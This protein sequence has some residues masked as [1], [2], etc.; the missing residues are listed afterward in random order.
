MNTDKRRALNPYLAGAIAGTVATAPMTLTMELL[1]RRLPARQQQPLPPRRLTM[2]VARRTRTAPLLPNEPARVGATLTAH[3][4]YGMLT[5]ALYPLTYTRPPRHP[6]LH[7]SL[8]G[9]AVWALSYLGWIPALRL[10][11]PA[12]QQRRERRRLM[13]AAHVVWGAATGL[14]TSWLSA[15]GDAPL[16]G[17]QQY[18]RHAAA[19]EISSPAAAV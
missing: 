13:L 16:T 14:L 10:L 6:V 19:A 17:F 12:T 15:D 7:G 5:G 9:L 4:G 3:F 18:R 8:Y 11:P 2:A 1:F